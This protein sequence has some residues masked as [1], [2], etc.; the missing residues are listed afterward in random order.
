MHI[1]NKNFAFVRSLDK[2][3]EIVKDELETKCVVF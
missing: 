3:K 2:C 1:L